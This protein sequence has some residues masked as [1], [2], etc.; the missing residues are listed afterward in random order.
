[1]AV[2]TTKQNIIDGIAHVNA[3][4]NNTI[5]TITDRQGNVLAWETS[6]KNGFR[7]S[8]KSTPFAAQIAASGAAEKAINNFGVK[9][10]E[11]WVSGPGTGRESATRA[12]N[13]AGLNVTVIKD[14]TPMPHNGCK[15]RKKR[16]V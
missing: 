4:F 15:P 5:V 16:R 14:V 2:K 9:N 11:V 13:N 10:I 7:G 3:T 12:L 6:G 8:R 1:M